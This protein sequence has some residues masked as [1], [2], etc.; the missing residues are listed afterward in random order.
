MNGVP[1]GFNSISPYLIFKDASVAIDFYKRVFGATELLRMTQPDGKIMHA[2]IEIGGSQV[3]LVDETPDFPEMQSALSVGGSPMHIHM[4][5]EDVDAAI[6]RAVN[7]G[8]KLLMPAKSSE[9]GERRGGV[10]DPFGFTWWIAT[11]EVAR[12]RAELQQAFENSRKG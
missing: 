5:V 1:Q 4:Y 12:T 2:E 9:D 6:E 3:M 10:Q 8:A 11:Q 7:A